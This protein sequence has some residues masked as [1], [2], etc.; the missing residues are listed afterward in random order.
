MAKIDSFELKEELYYW[1][2]NLS[3]ARVEAPNRVRVGLSDV[4]VRAAGEIVFIRFKPVGIAVKQGQPVAVVE[5]AKWVGPVESPVSGKIVEVNGELRKNP[6]LI[7]SD[8]YGVGWIAVV[9]PSNLSDDIR[10]L[11]KG[12]DPQ[13]VEWYREQIARL[14]KR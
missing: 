1:P 3:W 2:R 14:I 4:G 6:K 10:N 7:M 12:S 11:I 9:E 5:S 13:A 8:P